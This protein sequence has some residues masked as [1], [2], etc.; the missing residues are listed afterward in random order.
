MPPEAGSGNS[1]PDLRLAQLALDEGQGGREH[2]AAAGKPGDRDR[3]GRRRRRRPRRSVRQRFTR[4]SWVPVWWWTRPVA[5]RRPDVAPCRLLGPVGDDRDRRRYQ[6]LDGC[7]GDT[8]R[9]DRLLEARA[10]TARLAPPG[11]KSGYAL[12]STRRT[13]NSDL[14]LGNLLPNLC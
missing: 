1:Q 6:L 11:A 7:G 5:E 2:Q 8:P 3:A 4:R 12:R 13:A 9:R 14:R 10:D